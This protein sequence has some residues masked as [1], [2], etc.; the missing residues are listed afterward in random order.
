M[1]K[2]KISLGG[3]GAKI[4]V[5]LLLPLGGACGQQSLDLIE[6]TLEKSYAA[7]HLPAVDLHRG[8]AGADSAAYVLFDVR[9]PEEYDVSRI[10]QALQVDPETAAADFIAAHGQA[11]A[12]KKAVF[13]CSVGYRS[14]KLLK[15]V[16]TAALEAG[17]V[18][19][20]NLRGGIFRWYNEGL[21]L[22][23]E[24]DTARVHPYDSYW[25]K[26]LRK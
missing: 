6:I 11:I 18:S 4:T 16:E 8:L 10:G 24:G 1:K 3:L 25:G 5:A 22:K 23:A 15:R 13:Y 21:P 19:L 7:E 9:Q 20:A 17:A 26:L 14:S 2:I 12:G